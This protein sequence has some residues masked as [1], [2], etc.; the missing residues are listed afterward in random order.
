MADVSG[1]QDGLAGSRVK[2]R[3]KIE[4]DQG[5]SVI[6][7]EVPYG[8]TTESLIDSILA[9]QDKGKIK[10]A[11]ISDNT[12]ARVE[13]VVTFQRGVDMDKVM[14]AL[15]AFTECE[16][17]LSPNGMVIRDGKPVAMSVTEMVRHNAD[18]TRGLLKRDLEIRRDRLELRWH[19]KSLVQIFVENRIYLRIEKAKTWEAVLSEIDKGLDPFKK[20]LRQAVTHDDLVM[21]TEVKIRRISA[22][23]AEKAKEEL[24]AIDKEIKQVK[25]FLRKLTD[26]TIAYFD[27]LIADYG[28]GR[29]R[30]TELASF[31]TVKAVEVVERTEK[32]YVERASGF[33]GTDLKGGEEV[34][35]CSSIDNVLVILED[36]GLFVSKVD[37]RKYI[38]EK[39]VYV[40]V[41][42]PDDRDTV[43]NIVY[44]HRKKERA[45]VKRFT[46]GGA[47]RD[48]RYELGKSAGDTRVHHVSV[49]GGKFVYVK[50]RKKPRIRTDLYFRFDD[51]AVKGRGAGGN[52]ITKHRVSS[53]QDI[54]E[55]VYMN[56]LGLDELPP[57]SAADAEDEPE[58]IA[59]PETKKNAERRPRRT[60][61]RN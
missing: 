54:S 22:W 15:Y 58:E 39:I 55:N 49:G 41:F 46:V 32:L 35:P 53:A 27:R 5:K 18:Q 38:G 29:E 16:T 8:V 37:G 20:Q 17:T 10:V 21:L 12:G 50:L 56:R 26:Y 61:N 25:G 7:R 9:A 60:S 24:S 28:K 45:F 52:T 34:G 19:H 3:A 40:Q 1:Y 2:V 59:A 11:N 33:I 6:I 36:G 57:P 51:F 30:K 42:G 13:I 31:D 14:D 47:T 48:K 23:D 4:P 43:F 44:E